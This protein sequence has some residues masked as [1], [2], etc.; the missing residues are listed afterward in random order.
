M[1]ALKNQED[2]LEN[3]D[4]EDEEDEEED[5]LNTIEFEGNMYNTDG[6]YLYDIETGDAVG[7]KKGGQFKFY[8]RKGKKKK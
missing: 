4:E 3:K 7:Y 5:E 2:S 8:K 1:K 6:Q